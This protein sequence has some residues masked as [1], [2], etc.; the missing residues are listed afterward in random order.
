M[1]MER[2]TVS[3][4]AAGEILGISRPTA[5]KLA[6]DGKLPVLKLGPRKWVVPMSALEK[7]MENAGT[8]TT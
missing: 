5:Y 1:E 6:H 4:E 2:K 3:I 8:S 7:F